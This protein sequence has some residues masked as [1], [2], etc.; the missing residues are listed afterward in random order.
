MFPWNAEKSIIDS[1]YRIIGNLGQGG[2]GIVY[3][4]EDMLRDNITFAVKTIKQNVLSSTR[5]SGIDSFKNEYEIMTRLKHPN[6]TQVFDFGR[7]GDNYYIVMEYLQGRMLSDIIQESKKKPLESCIEYMIQMLRALEYVHSRDIIYRDIKPGNIMITEHGLKFLDF[8]LSGLL[9]GREKNV[10]GT[11]LYISP[12]ALSG[13]IQYSMDMFSLGLLFFELTAG[14]P[15][16]GGRGIEICDIIQILQDPD[17]YSDFQ[18]KRLGLAGSSGFRAIIDGMTKYYP[19]DRYKKFSDIIGDINKSFN[20]AYEYESSET[21]E[22]YVLGNAFADRHREMQILKDGLAGSRNPCMFIYR[23]TAGAG[24]TRLFRELK[25]HCRLNSIPYFESTCMEGGI[26]E[27][28]SICEMLE[29]M[30]ILSSRELLQRYGTNLKHI[31]PGF[32]YLAEFP[33]PD[34]SDDPK[35]LKDIIIQNATDFILGFCRES[36]YKAAICFDDLQWIDEG[37]LEMLRVLLHKM[38]ISETGSKDLIIIANIDEGKIEKKQEFAGFFTMEGLKT[39]DLHPLDRNGVAEFIEKIF[40]SRFID[41]SIRKSVGKMRDM[42]S[43]NPLF[44]EQLIKSLIENDLIIKDRGYWRLTRDIDDMDIPPNLLEIAKARL[45]KIMKEKDYRNVLQI[46][47]LLRTDLESGLIRAIIKSTTDSDAM[48]IVLDLERLE[49]MQSIRTAGSFKYSFASSTVKY[50]VRETVKNSRKLHSLL[51]DI[52]DRNYGA[53]S[54]LFTE[55]TAYHYEKG[56]NTDKAVE[57]YIK[58]G[59]NAQSRYFNEKAVRFYDIALKLKKGSDMAEILGVLIRKAISLKELG[60]W[61]DALEILKDCALI[62]ERSENRLILG[63]INNIRGSILLRKGDL[64]SAGCS[65]EESRRIAESENNY[66]LL[67]ETITNII[68]Y[69][70]YK[71]QY[72]TAIDIFNN[73]RHVWEK[74]GDIRGYSTALNNI[75]NIYNIQSRFNEAIDCF[76]SYRDISIKAGDKKGFAKAVCNMGN[77]YNNQGDYKKALECYEVY[78][79]I[80]EET[81]DKRGIGSAAGNIGIIYYDLG[82]YRKALDNHLLNMRLSMELGDK[83]GAGIAYGNL[84]ILYYDLGEYDK[85]L[86]YHEKRKKVAEE[87][88]DRRGTGIAT[89]NMGTVYCAMGHYDKALKSYEIYKKISEEIGDRMGEGAA[90]GNIGGVLLYRGDFQEA[91]KMLKV[92]EKI[93]EETGD[94]RSIGFASGNMGKAYYELGRKDMA[95][96]CFNKAADI[97]RALGI[98]SLLA[99]FLCDKSVLHLDNREYE[100]AESCIQELEKT[101]AGLRDKALLFNMEM[102]RIRMMAVSNTESAVRRMLEMLNEERSRREKAEICFQLYMLKEEVKYRKEALRL[103]SGLFEEEPLYEFEKRIRILKKKSK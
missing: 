32:T 20:R 29:R 64:E 16:F 63:K 80:S 27:Y 81:G 92:R 59:D 28:Y 96:R 33:D 76:I 85:A 95:L 94:K 70:F 26:K 12:E 100:D 22:S 69:Y 68:N 25:K 97:F 45:E 41:E 19:M 5:H 101:G 14:E 60:Q 4:A 74:C 78:K 47:S 35:A 98:K 15:F 9:Q 17:H 90:S 86:D 56:E 18:E 49:I 66:K 79:K 89:A 67:A 43:G 21:K 73:N 44:L 55:E 7:D 99:E 65:F 38:N 11:L 6:L 31:L 3:L 103:Y 57:Y 42:V 2:M 87:I 54:D 10:K 62:A 46:L 88:G 30:I 1:R 53:V 50:L 13:N 91:L 83:I 72:E 24:K 75:G 51:A 36:R 93:A 77:V 61:D 58:C 8:G 71:S 40:G 102:L 84:G 39:A 48:R 34:G 82:N 37:S 52:L 23:G